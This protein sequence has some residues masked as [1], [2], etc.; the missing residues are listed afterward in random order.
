MGYGATCRVARP[1]MMC[2]MAT[3]MSQAHAQEPTSPQTPEDAPMATPITYAVQ[4]EHTTLD[5]LVRYDRAALIP[6]HDHVIQAQQTTGT[7]VWNAA[8]PSACAIN[9]SFPAESLVVDP[10]TTRAQ[11][12]F[13][14]TTS[15][16]EK[17]K[18]RSNMLGKA[19]LDAKQFP[20]ITFMSQS[21]RP[22]GDGFLIQGELTVRGKAKE[23]KTLMLVTADK[24]HFTAKGL[25]KTSHADFGMKP[26][27]AALGAVRNADTLAF[28]V[29]VVARPK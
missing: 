9:L 25:F 3:L 1:L 21:C 15:N 7:V 23:V 11:Y 14:G 28:H 20:T 19:Q 29:N 27:R 5:V 26:Y 8:D 17:G 22:S 13:D 4:Q 24:D 12:G 2:L 18:I 16:T 6:G 10:G